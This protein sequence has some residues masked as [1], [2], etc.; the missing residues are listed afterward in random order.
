MEKRSVIPLPEFDLFG[1]APT[2]TTVDE[3]LETII[4]PLAPLESS[5]IIEFIIPSTVYEYICLNET[6]VFVKCQISLTKSSGSPAT[7]DWDKI[8][9]VNYLIGSLFKSVDVQ[10]GDKQITM[11]PQTYAYRAYFDCVINFGKNAQTSWLSIGLFD[12]DDFKLL[13]DK[14]KPVKE[15]SEIF[16]PSSSEDAKLSKVVQLIGK[17]HTDLSLQHKALL[18]GCTVKIRLQLNDSSFFL[19]NGDNLLTPK[20]KLQECFLNVVKLRVSS[21]VLIGHSKALNMSAA[22]YPITREEVKTFTVQINTSSAFLEN[23][24]IGKLPT[25]LYLALVDNQAFLGNVSLNPFN[26]QHFDLNYLAFF[27]NGIQFPSI[28]YT[29]NFKSNFYMREL[30]NFIKVTNHYD[31]QSKMPINRKNYA[32]G[33]IIFGFNFN[34]DYSDGYL[35]SGFVNLPKTGILR[36][37]LRFSTPLPKTINALLFCEYDSE[38]YITKERNALTDYN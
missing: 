38:I 23:I 9:P 25:K 3:R 16:K 21:D 20:F 12:A 24:V 35:K 19:L 22:I 2:Q 31:N 18:G 11:S 10:I 26:F 14:D 13:T 34:S 7:A 17:L 1:N 36:A 37:E 5:Q 28:A 32:S 33:N 30:N 27:V 6:E 8:S 4:R 29:P 15:R